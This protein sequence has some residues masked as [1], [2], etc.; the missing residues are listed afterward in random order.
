MKHKNSH[1]KRKFQNENVG[2]KYQ[3]NPEKPEFWGIALARIKSDFQ[4]DQCESFINYSHLSYDEVDEPVLFSTPEPQMSGVEDLIQNFENA[5]RQEAS[6][7]QPFRATEVIKFRQTATANYHREHDKW[8]SERDDFDD[9]CKKV[10]EIFRK[11]FPPA[12]FT[13]SLTER[14]QTLSSVEKCE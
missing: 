9:K 2:S 5:L 3:F 4:I 10:V 12:V 13:L 11:H 1:G 14:T 6:A 8:K 7:H